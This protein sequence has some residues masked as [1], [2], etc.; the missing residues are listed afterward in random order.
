M[1]SRSR[2]GLCRGPGLGGRRRRR[3][4]VDGLARPAWSS[5]CS[6]SPRS[7][8][9]P[10]RSGSSATRSSSTTSPLP[11][12]PAAPSRRAEAAASSRSG[13]EF[14]V[15]TLRPRDGAGDRPG[16]Q[17]GPHPRPRPLPGALQLLHLLLGRPRPGRGASL[18][19]A[20]TSC[21]SG[22]SAEERDLV[23]PGTIRLRRRHAGS[24]AACRSAAKGASL[25][26]ILAGA[27]VLVAAAAAAAAI[28][29]AAGP[30][31]L[32]GDAG[33][34]RLGPDPD[35]R[36]S[37]ALPPDRR[38]ARPSR[39][40]IVAARDARRRR[41]SVALAAVFRRWPSCPAAG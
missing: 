8:P 18:R 36:R 11:A 38:P 10:G 25:S 39:S 12:A 31:A 5:R 2:L 14:R 40:H 33:R 32:G 4:L 22:C 34:A 28:L 26:A 35:P 16:G 3:C 15:T 17:A 27:G 21:G 23:P 37:V 1:S 19:P 30:P 41:C 24:T 6:S 7:L 29:T 13:F 20:A 9:S